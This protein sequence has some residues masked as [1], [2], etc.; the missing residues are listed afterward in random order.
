VGEFTLKLKLAAFDPLHV[1][2]EAMQLRLPVLQMT[3]KVE[4][5]RREF[6]IVL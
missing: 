5:L 6:W 2:I 4:L 3:G 1:L